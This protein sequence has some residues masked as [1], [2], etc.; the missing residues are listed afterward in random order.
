[1][2]SG[3]RG[4]LDVARFKGRAKTVSAPNRRGPKTWGHDNALS[5]GESLTG[6]VILSAPKAARAG[7]SKV[8]HF[9]HLIIAFVVKVSIN[10][11][12]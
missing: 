4:F 2:R 7:W 5:R 12:R 11:P 9:L 3:Q 6:S 8:F 1:V 10:R